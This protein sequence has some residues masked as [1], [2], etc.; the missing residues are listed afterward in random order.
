[1]LQ[2]YFYEEET[3]KMETIL[4][5]DDDK[6]IR[7]TLKTLLEENRY[8][9]FDASLCE[10]SK[11]ILKDHHV[12]LVLL[13]IHLPDGNGLDLIP[14]LKRI[15]DV[16]LIMLSASNDVQEKVRALTDGADDYLCKPVQ[17]A[18]LL[19]RIK[20]SLKR[21][22]DLLPRKCETSDIFYDWHVDHDK[23]QLFD[24]KGY[25]A[26]L[27]AD[28]YKLLC[29]LLSNKGVVLS[30]DDLCRHIAKQ[31]YKPAPRTIDIKIARIRKKLFSHQDNQRYLKTVRGFGYYVEE[32]TS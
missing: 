20:L 22:Q 24:K 4:I 31:N 1:M 26:G 27:T 16:P 17:K 25:S 7:V 3:M 19:A 30:R 14:Q 18:E 5:V 21:Y 9:V 23:Y 8:H 28:E 2:F 10:R 13:D 12:D 6:T 29:Y 11:D 15:T 32:G